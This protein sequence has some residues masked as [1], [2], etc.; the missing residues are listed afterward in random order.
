MVTLEEL[1]LSS[2]SLC[3]CVCMC[4][5]VEGTT[6]SIQCSLVGPRWLSF[7][8]DW[9]LR[10]QNLASGQ[11]QWRAAMKC[12]RHLYSTPLWSQTYRFGNSLVVQWLGLITLPAKGQG[13][14]PGWGTKIPQAVRHS[15]KKRK[16]KQTYRFT[17]VPQSSQVHS[18]ADYNPAGRFPT[19]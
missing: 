1:I 9:D 4:V 2:Q 19:C 17:W 13:S 5:C 7:S 16:Q 14:S 11:Y 3:V 10:E 12:W 6:R 8:G 15:L 18:E